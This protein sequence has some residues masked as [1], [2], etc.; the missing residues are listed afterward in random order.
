MNEQFHPGSAIVGL[1]FIALGAF[2]L[3]DEFDVVRMR[4]ALILPILLIGLGLGLV[5]SITDPSRRI[6]GTE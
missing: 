6:H 2:F 5:V 1:V 4:P 3:L